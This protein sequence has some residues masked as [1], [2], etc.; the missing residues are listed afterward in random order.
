MIQAKFYVDYDSNDSYKM[1]YMCTLKETPKVGD[2]IFISLHA[3]QEFYKILGSEHP[4]VLEQKESKTFKV[5]Q[6][7]HILD[8]NNYHE[9]HLRVK[10]I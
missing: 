6:V 2:F 1:F 3:M 5:I 9:I 7:V 4:M 8:N 10:E